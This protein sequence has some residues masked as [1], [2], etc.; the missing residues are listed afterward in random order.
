MVVVNGENQFR[1]YARQNARDQIWCNAGQNAGIQFGQN[2]RNQQR[3]TST[4]ADKTPVYD[5]D[6]S[7]EIHQHENC[8]NNKIF[9]MF[10]QEG[11]YTKLLESTT[12]TYLV[13]QNDSNVIHMDSN[14]DL[15]GGKVEQHLTTIEETRAF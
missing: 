12:D 5:S 2:A 13:Q 11:Q 14:M 6:G 3:S 1:L 9:N 4:H 8:Y 10:A 7:A 15:S